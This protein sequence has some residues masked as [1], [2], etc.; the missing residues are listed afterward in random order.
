MLTRSM[1]YHRKPLFYLF[2]ALLAA[3][4][5]AGIWLLVRSPVQN[6]GGQ[7]TPAPV[8]SPAN[9][10]GNQ[11]TLI[12]LE[13]YQNSECIRSLEISH[14]NEEQIVT[15]AILNYMV[16]SAAWEGVDVEAL[17]DYIRI[18]VKYAGDE[19]Y[20]IFYVF[21]LDGS[22]CMQPGAAGRYATLNEEAYAPLLELAEGY[23]L[24]DVMTVVS[25]NNTVQSAEHRI[26]TEQKKDHLS[27]DGMRLKPVDVADHIQYLTLDRDPESPAP[28][29][30]YV[31]GEKVYGLYRLYNAETFEELPILYPTG[32]AP[33]THLF[34][35]IGPGIYL[36]AVEV[37]FEND[38]EIYGNQYFFG[39]IVPDPSVTPMTV[40][41]GGDTI[42]VP[43]FVIFKREPGEPDIVNPG[44]VIRPG[45]DDLTAI[46]YGEDMALTIGDTPVHI[47]RG[48]PDQGEIVGLCS[49]YDAQG[50]MLDNGH[51]AASSIPPDFIK[52]EIPGRYIVEVLIQEDGKDTMVHTQYVF[53]IDIT[54]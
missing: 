26:W 43:G 2:I 42:S 16:K 53:A 24:P 5:A 13:L 31:R 40:T 38:R 7:A 18:D 17:E 39:V 29:T 28:F 25:G 12:A 30:P 49:V 33:Q 22:H 6:A 23:F 19:A 21:D 46:P 32:I 36:V 15:D 51:M 45:T 14:P 4:V 3:A 34:H 9:E 27:A 48:E 50:N 47:F 41:C 20:T 35:K 10:A 52:P 44:Y 11:F 1:L 37:S 8:S 54:K